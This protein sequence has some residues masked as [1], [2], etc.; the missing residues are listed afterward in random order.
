MKRPEKIERGKQLKELF[1]SYRYFAFFDFTGITVAQ[2]NSLR[3]ALRKDGA[4]IKVV[5]NRVAKKVM[6]GTLA[7]EAKEWLQ[8]PTAVVFIKD[9]VGK[10]VKELHEFSKEAPLK[11]KG[12]ILEGKKLGPEKAEE[13]AS[14]P[15]REE[16]VAQ[17]AAAMAAPLVM[18]GRAM[19]MPLSML[20]NALAQLKEKKEKGE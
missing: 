14:L 15:T 7:Q 3:S 13:L 6:D 20:A 4:L 9:D 11:F 16:L 18:F 8:G 1:D 12:F 19:S 2:M 5:K 17:I 10:A